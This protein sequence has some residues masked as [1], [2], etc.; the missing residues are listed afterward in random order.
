[1]QEEEEVVVVEEEEE[2]EDDDGEEESDE[3]KTL[4]THYHY[5]VKW[6]KRNGSVRHSEKLR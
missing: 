2:E 3:I 1:M 6:E 4:W 5:I